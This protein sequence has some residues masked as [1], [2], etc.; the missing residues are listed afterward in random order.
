MHTGI[1]SCPGDAPL[2]EVA[3]MMAR[4]RVHAIAVT[5]GERQRP[6]GVITTL[7]VVTAIAS[8]G[9]PTAHQAAVTES[10]SI[11]SGE[12]L[13]HAAQLMA[14]HGVSHLVVLDSAS[15]YPVGVLSTLDIAAAYSGGSR[16]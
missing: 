15:G 12:P 11:S 16:A 1:F 8:G 10:I 9:E 14:E 2:G 13:Q 5:N 4:H 7:D 6:V 3:A